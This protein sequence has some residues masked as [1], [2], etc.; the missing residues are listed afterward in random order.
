MQHEDLDRRSL[1]RTAAMTSAASAGLANSVAARDGSDP[2]RDGKL[3]PERIDD[4]RATEIRS[5]YDSPE[6]IRQTVETHADGLLNNL[7][8]Q[9]ILDS[10]SVEDLPLEEFKE[11]RRT[12]VPADDPRGVG[13]DAVRI[14]GKDTAL[15]TVSA[16]T[17]D[18]NLSI[19]VQPEREKSY[20]IVDRDDGNLLFSSAG[21]CKTGTWEKH[22]CQHPGC[23]WFRPRGAELACC[24]T[25]KAP[26]SCCHESDQY[27]VLVK[28]CCYCC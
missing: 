11:G 10:G 2:S 9:G 25:R 17:E 27:C 12:L 23:T 3:P 13:I 6:M 8:E 21:I 16:N 22:P 18:E 28:D 20:S 19:Y 4:V 15:I 26:P 24:C 5:R 1:L 14:D 7:S